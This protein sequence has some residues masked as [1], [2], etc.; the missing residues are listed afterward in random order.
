M[1]E[2]FKDIIDYEGLYQI[3]NLGRV[4]CLTKRGVFPNGGIVVHKEKIMATRI[5]A[6]YVVIGLRKNSQLNTVKVH[7]L[8]CSA[9]HPNQDN[10]P[11]VNHLDGNKLNNKADNVE[12][13]TKKENAQHALKMGLNYTNPLRGSKNS[14]AKLNEDK[15]IKIRWLYKTKLFTQKKLG[16]MFEIGRGSISLIIQNKRWKH[17]A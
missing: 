4:K 14:M 2:I 3:S 7:R 15:V 6:T 17:V 13:S 8:V 5:N 12:W 9:F 1:E 11:D 16:E 10:K